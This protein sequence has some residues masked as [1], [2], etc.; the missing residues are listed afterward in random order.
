MHQSSFKIALAASLFLLACTSVKE[1]NQEPLDDI[2]STEQTAE[3]EVAWAESSS[4]VLPE[5]RTGNYEAEN[6]FD[7]DLSTAWCP[8]PVDS[9]EEGPFAGALIL[10]FTQSPSGKTM[11]IFPGFARDEKTYWENNRI[12][13]LVV[14][15]LPSPALEDAFLFDLKDEYGF[16]SIVLPQGLKDTIMLFSQEVYPGSKYDDTCIAEIQLVD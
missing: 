8:A 3:S 14:P 2:V 15:G 16:Q 11:N 1:E 13:T 9:S 6:V 5:D 10:H 4:A 12:K 7:G